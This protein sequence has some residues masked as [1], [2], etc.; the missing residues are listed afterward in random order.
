MGV[1]IETYRRR[2]GSHA[3]R[4]NH[5]ANRSSSVRH[6]DNDG[7]GD[8]EFSSGNSPDSTWLLPRTVYRLTR[9][10]ARAGLLATMLFV[11]LWVMATLQD[12]SACKNLHDLS[13]LILN[14][15]DIEEDPGPGST[16]GSEATADSES[17]EEISQMRSDVESLEAKWEQQFRDLE[18]KMQGRVERL[19]A[20][21][22]KQKGELVQIADCWER[23]V[24][25]V[26]RAQVSIQRDMSDLS[27]RVNEVVSDLSTR[28]D[29]VADY[30]QNI[31]LQNEDQADKTEGM[32]IRNNIKMYGVYEGE[33]ESYWSCVQ[34]V[35]N[36]LR[37]ALPTVPWSEKDIVRV[38]RLGPARGNNRYKPRP[39]LVQMNTLLDKLTLLKFGRDVLRTKGIQISSELTRRQARILSDLREQGHEAFF[40]NG[41]LWFRDP[42]PNGRPNYRSQSSRPQRHGKQGKRA[43]KNDRHTTDWQYAPGNVHQASTEFCQG[44]QQEYWAQPHFVTQEHSRTVESQPHQ[45]YTHHARE[46]HQ[47]FKTP[48]DVGGDPPTVGQDGNTDGQHLYDHR[49]RKPSRWQS[50]KA[51]CSWHGMNSALMQKGRPEATRKSTQSPKRRGL[52][53][54][55]GNEH[56]SDGSTA[57]SD[58]DTSDGNMNTFHDHDG[59]IDR[60]NSERLLTHKRSKQ[61]TI[62][63]WLTKTT[64]NELAVD[65]EVVDVTGSPQPS[66]SPTSVW[67]GRLRSTSAPTRVEECREYI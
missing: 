54:D 44:S 56:D 5:V 25:E 27:T 20:Q 57:N 40:R 8:F 30:V 28:V 41:R 4:V 37:E 65:T 24:H 13:S 42:K 6:G 52:L 3:L 32:F 50:E 67:T 12:G 43:A 55:I 29:E 31:N 9:S 17:A 63:E 35:L 53:P 36:V 46:E 38:Q 23:D 62:R 18:R 10:R 11:A 15:G 7:V 34:T 1:D 33:R 2:I 51:S 59:V 58:V 48:T 16:A 60:E 26:V 21:L 64:E 14:A 19:E 39:L 66:G 47:Q 61:T 49:W 22:A 45:G